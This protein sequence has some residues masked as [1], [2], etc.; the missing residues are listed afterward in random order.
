MTKKLKRNAQRPPKLKHPSA[1]AVASSAPELQYT[2]RECFE[3]C[4]DKSG[5]SPG[6]L[7]HHRCMLNRW[8]RFHNPPI[9]EITS[10]TLEWVRQ[11]MLDAGLTPASVNTG[12]TSYRAILR[13]MGPQFTGNPRGLGVLP[14]IP[15][16]RPCQVVRSRPKRV[17]LED[18]SRFYL[19]TRT[20]TRT[21]NRVCGVYWWQALIVLAYF[22][23]LRKSDLFSLRWENIDLDKAELW[24]QSSKTMKGDLFPLHPAAVQH[25]RR[26]M[27]PPRERLFETSMH[28][29]GDLGYRWQQIL[30]AADIKERFTLHDIRR[31]AASEIE[32]IKPGMGAVF[33]QHVDRSVT[34]MFYLNR[35]DD[36]RECI[37]AMRVPIAFA[38]GPKQAERA[39]EKARQE[40]KRLTE[41]M[42]RA[43]AFTPPSVPKP[44]EWKFFP[45]G[46][47]IRGFQGFL[48]GAPWRALQ[49]L[50]ISEVQ[51]VDMRVL[52]KAIFRD[53]YKRPRGGHVR[54]CQSVASVVSSVRERL[55]RTLYLPENYDPLPCMERGKGGKWMIY[56][57]T[58]LRRDGAA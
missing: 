18:L 56:L 13:R 49:V 41:E 19:A 10:E 46:F 50:A 27:H 54:V 38:H 25:L 23:G 42:A 6:G 44:D 9:G 16:M 3:K 31:T 51:P 32:R 35:T 34:G 11:Q 30:K 43:A 36:L 55:R 26:I 45:G 58:E 8:E 28:K 4:Y 20:I 15:W 53:G 5:I 14:T 12:R 33:L 2:L 24:H 21:V 48:S 52:A 39:M 47:C 37:N 1:G 22:T 40:L 7:K 17:S 29:G 57:P